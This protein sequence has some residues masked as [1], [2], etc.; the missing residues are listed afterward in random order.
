MAVGWWW[1]VSFTFQING[2]NI[3]VIKFGEYLSDSLALDVS[4][5]YTSTFTDYSYL[6]PYT[7]EIQKAGVWGLL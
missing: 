6:N 4:N 3:E 7:E 2:T 5:K 1:W